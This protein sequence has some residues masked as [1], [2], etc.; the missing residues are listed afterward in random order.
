[1]T[2]ALQAVS[3]WVKAVKEKYGRPDTKYACVGYCFGAPFVCNELAG[4]TVTAGAFGH[5][6]LLE[7]YHFSNLKGRH[8]N[9]HVSITS[10]L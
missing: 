8:Y 4:S 9:D 10:Y 3:D 6:A 2:F 1:M 5:P 7:D